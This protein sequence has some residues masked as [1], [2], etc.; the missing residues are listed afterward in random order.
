[1]TT[2]LEVREALCDI[3]ANVVGLRAHPYPTD[4]ITAPCA[5]VD[6]DDFDP[7]MVFGE[8]VSTY[9]FQVKAYYPR[10][11][12]QAAQRSIDVLRA[13]SG[14]GSLMEAVQDEANWPDELVHYCSVTRIGRAEITEIAAEPLFVV[15]FDLEVVF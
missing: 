9:P 6:L 15:E 14:D 5:Y 7:R 4:T 10:L 12:D 13:T 3:L 8:Q 11:A 1:M 2:T